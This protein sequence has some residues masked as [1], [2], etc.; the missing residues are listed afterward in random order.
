MYVASESSP[1]DTLM[2]TFYT[3]GDYQIFKPGEGYDV[4][5]GEIAVSQGKG[6]RSMLI[7]LSIL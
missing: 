4:L 1:I 3:V 5:P 7:S 6:F 2:K